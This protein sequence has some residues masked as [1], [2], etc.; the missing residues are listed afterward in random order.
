MQVNHI[1]KVG[2]FGAFGNRRRYVYLYH[3]SPTF[4]PDIIEGIFGIYNRTGIRQQYNFRK[5]SPHGYLPHGVE[6]FLMLPAGITRSYPHVNPAGRN[7]PLLSC[8][9]TAPLRR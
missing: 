4:L 3:A 8:H 1:G 5:T 9:F 6:V 2:T 7:T